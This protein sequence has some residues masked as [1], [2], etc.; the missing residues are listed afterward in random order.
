LH[1]YCKLIATF[2]IIWTFNL[3]KDSYITQDTV[4]YR[5]EIESIRMY[6]GQT[7]CHFPTLPS[8]RGTQPV[9]IVFVLNGRGYLLIHWD[10]AQNLSVNSLQSRLYLKNIHNKNLHQLLNK[11]D[12]L[13]VIGVVMPHY[14]REAGSKDAYEL[15]RYKR[16]CNEFTDKF[17]AL[18]QCIKRYSIIIIRRKASNRNVCPILSQIYIHTYNE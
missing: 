3:F 17:W 4:H 12:L 2:F 8:K 6:I 11:K 18:S 16:L 14:C 10:N 15:H 9:E 1:L 13:S 5:T 7:L